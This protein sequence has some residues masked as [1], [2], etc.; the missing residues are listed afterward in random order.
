MDEL[1]EKG[2][3]YYSDWLVN[4]DYYTNTETNYYSDNELSACIIEEQNTNKVHVCYKSVTVGKKH[5]L[6]KTNIVP[7]QKIDVVTYQG[8]TTQII[9]SLGL[10]LKY[11][12]QIKG[13]IYQFK[14]LRVSEGMIYNK[15]VKTKDLIVK[16]IS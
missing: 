1:E 9:K 10:E 11:S 8:K 2:S 15:H 3:K 13:K 14:D 5:E 16:V 7:H 6:D 4:L 12:K